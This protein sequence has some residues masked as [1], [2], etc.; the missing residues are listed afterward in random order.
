VNGFNPFLKLSFSCLNRKFI[1]GYSFEMIDRLTDILAD[2]FK[3]KTIVQA[4][5]LY[6]SYVSGKARQTSDVDIAVLIAPFKRSVE[7]YQSRIA[8]ISELTQ[9]LKRV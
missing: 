4:A 1:I 7:S 3:H 9:L 6:G 5:Y 8:F 2:Y